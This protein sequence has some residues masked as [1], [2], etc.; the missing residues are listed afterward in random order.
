MLLFKGGV[1]IYAE[2]CISF[3]WF[4]W[5]YFFTRESNILDKGLKFFLVKNVFMALFITKMQLFTLQDFNWW[6]VDYCYYLC[7]YLSMDCIINYGIILV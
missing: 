2:Y 5:D 3:S 7:I 6:T 4:R 1:L